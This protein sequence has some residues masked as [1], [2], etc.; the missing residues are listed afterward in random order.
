[1]ELKPSKGLRV[2]VNASREAIFEDESVSVKPVSIE[3]PKGKEGVL[4]GTILAGFCE[5]EMPNLD[6]KKHWYP[7]DQLTGEG[8]EPLVEEELPIDVSSDEEE[9]EP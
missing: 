9:E 7:I 1:M 8:G 4:T 6:G 3:A 5:V 2:K